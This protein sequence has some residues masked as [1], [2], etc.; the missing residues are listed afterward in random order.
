MVGGNRH[1]SPVFVALFLLSLTKADLVADVDRLVRARDVEGL[2]KK[3]DPLRAEVPSPF[4]L[5][6]NGG[7]Y[8]V[9]KFGWRALRLN[10]V[11]NSKRYIVITTPMTSEDIGEILLEQN[12]DHLR[13]VSEAETFGVKILNHSLLVRFKPFEKKAYLTDEMNLN[14]IR[15]SGP[16]M[17]RVSPNYRISRVLDAKNEPLKFSQAGGVIL[18]NCTRSLSFKLKIEYSVVADLKGYAGSIDRSEATL[19]NDYWIP[20]VGRNPAPYTLEVYAPKDWVVIGQGERAGIKNLGAES[21]TKYRMDLPVTYYSLT[22][23]PYPAVTTVLRG[24]EYTTWSRR[25]SRD[26]MLVQNQ[27]LADWRVFFEKL[28]PLPFSRYGVLDSEAYGGGALEAY[29]YATYGGDLPTP[30][31]HELSHSWFG[32]ILDNTYLHSFWNES[33]ANFSEGFYGRNAPIG[34][35]EDREFAFI[36]PAQADPLDDRGS[37]INSGFTSGKVGSRMGYGKG[38]DV[39]QMLELLIGTNAMFRAEQ[40]WIQQQTPREPAE[41]EGFLKA[42]FKVAPKL[43]LQDFMDDWM[44]RP[45]DADFDGQ[46]EFVNREV[47]IKLTWNEKRFRMP[48]RI[49][50]RYPTQDVYKTIDTGTGDAISISS[51]Q[52]PLLVSIDPYQEVLRKNDHRVAPARLSTAVFQWHRIKDP[53]SLGTLDYLG[54]NFELYKPGMDLDQKFIVGSPKSLPVLADLCRQAGFVMSGNR[55]TYHGQTIDLDK[56]AAFSIVE[57][58]KGRACA[59]GL[60]KLRCV[61]ELG[62]SSTAVTDDLGRFLCGT[63]LPITTGGLAFNF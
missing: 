49:L 52:K 16:F 17:F 21:V 24:K 44:R 50:M 13:Y 4:P 58:G 20:M 48:L 51:E 3:I 36:R 45:G 19:T 37:V 46:A 63:T 54:K 47:Q 62:I 12:G 15:R 39:L 27:L 32:G 31:P 29:S 56:G 53:N 8:E 40:T 28:C 6:R 23:G 60:G 11:G 10:S 38:A 2:V 61:P 57:L 43:R 7:A 22:A 9:G 5:I 41:W 18:L 30:S 34:R 33:F 42:V 35:K 25:L 14:S 55:L 26:E 1:N 59:I